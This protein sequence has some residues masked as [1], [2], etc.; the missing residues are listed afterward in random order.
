[1]ELNIQWT[2]DP[3][4]STVLKLAGAVDL[5]SR[6]ELIEAGTEALKGSSG[7]LVLDLAGVTFV[8]ST[9]LGAF[10]ELRH[11]A[12]DVGR[13]IVLRNPTPRTR[14]LFDLT[15]LGD[16]LGDEPAAEDS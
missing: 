10:I 15:G 14:R 9:G 6:G 11:S 13:S 1:M 12:S 16:L 2:E 8:D 5:S 3:S 7:P 4:G